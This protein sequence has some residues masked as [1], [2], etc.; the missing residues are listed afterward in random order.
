V[1]INFDWAVEDVDGYTFTHEQ[2]RELYALAKKAHDAAALAPE[3]LKEI[4]AVLEHE[5]AED[6]GC[7]DQPGRVLAAANALREMVRALEVEREQIKA[8]HPFL[9]DHWEKGP[10]LVPRV[11]ALAQCYGD[12]RA[13]EEYAIGL[14][15][16]VKRGAVWLRAEIRRLEAELERKK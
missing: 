6:R 7:V 14:H 2:F 4:D 8:L 11:R 3:Q 16:G 12:A 9:A 5:N 13:T 15:H 1:T 10:S